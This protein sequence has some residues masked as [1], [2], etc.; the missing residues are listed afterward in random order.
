[1]SSITALVYVGHPHPYEDHSLS[2][3]FVIELWEGDTATIV[4]RDI[5]KGSVMS[6]SRPD[7]PSLIGREITNMLKALA[8]NILAHSDEDPSWSI[9]V[10]PMPGS[11]LLED[12]SLLAT[13]RAAS[14]ANL[15]VFGCTYSRTRSG[16][17]PDW[18]ETGT[19]VA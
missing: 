6:R 3:E 1:M 12:S 17:S 8:P 18:N 15:H 11:S 4:A 2:P 9:L 5:R 16:W 14:G 7:K 13:L 10:V 19:L